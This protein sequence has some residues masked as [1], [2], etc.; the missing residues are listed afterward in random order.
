MAVLRRAANDCGAIRICDRARRQSPK[1]KR[2]ARFSVHEQPCIPRD[3]PK[4]PSE[5]P[6]TITY[7]SYIKPDQLAPVDP[8][9]SKPRVNDPD[10]QFFIRTHQVFETWFSQIISELTFCR[11]ILTQN[12][13]PERDIRGV[14]YTD[15]QGRRQAQADFRYHVESPSRWECRRVNNSSGKARYSDA[16]SAVR[17]FLNRGI[18]KQRTRHCTI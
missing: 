6:K 9:T 15:E 12:P 4:V 7:E 18:A 1:R 5:K 10:E 8:L 16:R 14:T 13:V 3:E 11:S 2:P 17:L